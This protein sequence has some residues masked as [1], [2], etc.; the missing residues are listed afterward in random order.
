MSDRLI[1][2]QLGLNPG[3]VGCSLKLDTSI[4]VRIADDLFR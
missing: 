1:R 3:I 4:A 2:C